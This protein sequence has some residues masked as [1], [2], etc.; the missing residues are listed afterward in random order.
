MNDTHV[1]GDP[2][3]MPDMPDM[4]T[5]EADARAL[6]Y[7]RR[8]AD[9][10]CPKGQPWVGNA[11]QLSGRQMHQKFTGW[12]RE[13]GPMFRLDV[14]GNP[15]VIVADSATV[16]GVLKER[17]EVFRRSGSLKTIMHELNIG[18]VITAEGD[19]WRKQR[20]LVMSGLSA[21]VIRNFFPTM[22]FMTERMMDRWKSRLAA[23][24]PVDLRRDLKAMAL[25]VIV[26]L[27]MGHD[28]DAVNDD[29]SPL[30]RNIDNIF[31]RLGQR[32]T[33]AF[34]YWRHFRLPVDRAADRSS[35]E[36]EA[37]VREFVR[38]TRA[39]MAQQRDLQQKP[40]NMLEAMIVAA[41]DPGSGFTDEELID[42]AVLSVIGGEDTTANSIAWMIHLLAQHP[43]AAAA[44]TSEVDAVLG[45]D[46]LVRDWEAMK[47]FDYLE[48][49]FSE[50]Q[51]LRSV[52]PYVG[53]TSNIDCVVADTFIPK[54]TAIVVATAGEGLDE[55][56]FPDNAS[57]QPG[58]W[59]FEQRP[60]RERDPARKLFPFGSGP[61]LCPGRFLALTEIKMVVS[62]IMRN[63]ELE[64]DVHA[65]P[66]KEVL[67]FFMA[68]SSL[69]V[70]I[71]L[72][73]PPGAAR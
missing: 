19:A 69:P 11:L 37:S 45:D 72:R 50:A 46:T 27:A 68:P 12:V 13:F 48:A 21:E 65:P 56:Q 10:P 57:F 28:I 42:N 20:K 24:K 33:A 47:R 38:D 34:P 44:L 23:G 30:Q 52:A 31:Q 63:F 54:N 15:I 8:I 26:G 14:F 9:L 59:I 32:T 43:Q 73:T 18:G 16:Q 60:P 40:G 58:R 25:D 6:R 51:R 36:V 7:S 71:R 2:L 67:N 39:R 3:A 5:T 4:P 64:L 22:R 70:R 62:M 53:V 1:T 49:T 66:V 41:E 35:T 29:G 61:R 55:A 17:P